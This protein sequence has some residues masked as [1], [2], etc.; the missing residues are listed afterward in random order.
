MHTTSFH[1]SCGF[2]GFLCFFSSNNH[3][4][5]IYLSVVLHSNNIYY[6]VLKFMNVL[7]CWSFIQT[8]IHKYMYFD[9]FFSSRIVHAE[10]ARDQF[11]G[12]HNVHKSDLIR[13]YETFYQRMFHF[14]ENILVYIHAC[15]S[16]IKWLFET[17]PDQNGC[18]KGACYYTKLCNQLF[19]Q[20]KFL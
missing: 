12:R 2:R 18:D 9:Y 17:E 1:P 13:S 16:H 6:S 19:V 15:I 14:W 10:S 3:F 11:Y 7:S 8:I 5:Y 20:G 4:I